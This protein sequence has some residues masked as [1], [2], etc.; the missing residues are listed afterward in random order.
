[1]LQEYETG[2]ALL[3]LRLWS[4]TEERRG[5]R[6][7]PSRIPGAGLGLFATQDFSEGDL[8]CV[9]FGAS[10]GTAQ[11]IRLQDKAY[12][13]RLGA[14]AYVDAGFFPCCSARYINDC[15]NPLGHNC[16]FEKI[17]ERR[18]AEVRAVRRIPRGSELYASYGRWYW[19]AQPSSRLSLRDLILQDQAMSEQ[20][21]EA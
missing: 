8:I 9:Y 5:T 19:L 10:L 18:S 12:L 15:R 3:L 13:M 7:A 16:R 2:A 20:R 4:E 17:P 11:A 14:D 6:I 21:A 1:M